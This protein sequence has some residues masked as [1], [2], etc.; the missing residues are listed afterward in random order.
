MDSGTSVKTKIINTG[1]IQSM[2]LVNNAVPKN[3]WNK[4]KDACMG[5]YL[6]HHYSFS[7]KLK[8]KNPN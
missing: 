7:V 1:K 8:K 6:R 5:I 2:K 4:V 3:K